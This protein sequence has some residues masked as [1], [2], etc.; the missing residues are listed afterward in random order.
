MSGEAL[1]VWG[2]A[3]AA[4]LAAGLGFMLAWRA[5][6]PAGVQSRFWNE[7]SALGLKA[8]TVDEVGEF[9]ATYRRLFIVLGGYL[10]RNFAIAA[11]GGTAVVV[12]ILGLLAPLQVHWDRRSA[13]LAAASMGGPAPTVRVGDALVFARAGQTVRVKDG[14]VTVRIAACGSGDGCRPLEWMGFTIAP[15]SGPLTKDATVIIRASHGDRNPLWPYLSDLEAIFGVGLLL[16]PLA[17]FVLPRR[18]VVSTTADFQLKAAD[19]ALVQINEQLK[20]LVRWAGDL[21]SKVHRARLDAIPLDR[22]IFVT[23]LARSGTTTVLSA[24]AR[25]PDLGSHQYQDFPFLGAPLA[26]NRLH[27]ALG[28]ETQAVER[29]HKDRILITSA[30]P[31]AFEEPLWRQFFP[32]EHEVG[33]NQRLSAAVTNPE[34]ESF[35]RDHLRKILHLRGALRYVS[36]GNYNV[37]RIEYLAKLFPDALFV[38]P[39][40][41]PMEHVASLCRQHALFRSYG[42]ADPR[43]PAYLAAAGHFEFGLQR[44]PLVLSADASERQ[45]GFESGDDIL[46][47]AEQWAEVYGHV[48][49]LL[50]QPDLAGRILLVRY[51]DFCAAPASGLDAILAFAGVADTGGAIRAYAS[52][53]SASPQT[54]PAEIT[55]RDEEVRSIVGDLAARLGYATP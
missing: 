37:G 26:W 14:D 42:E 18:Q 29:P 45:A 21:E 54:A 7:L 44:R 11:I 31:D 22:P 32:T 5:F 48:E 30:S 24:L 9:L 34:F 27:G 47:Y 25:S 8:I 16:S 12:A 39:V 40:R 49:R 51:E 6:L 52:E 38:V 19:F 20:P 4:G 15:R 1:T 2:V 23:G 55:A 10:G 35:F 50:N 41:R 28:K 17:I 13:T 53:I 46:A 36:K 43:V 3:L 33:A